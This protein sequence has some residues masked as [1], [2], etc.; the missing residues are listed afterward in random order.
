GAAVGAGLGAALGAG[1]FGG[2]AAGVLIAASALG[3]GLGPVVGPRVGQFVRNLSQ[4][5]GRAS[6]QGLLRTGLISKPLSPATAACLGALPAGLVA[7]FG[8]SWVY[9]DGS[10]LGLALGG[11]TQAL[12]LVDIFTNSKPNDEEE[13]Y[14]SLP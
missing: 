2:T 5:L 6:E 10:L 13:V 12:Q 11:T 7:E 4:D 14:A 1:G 9:S 3:G 8:K